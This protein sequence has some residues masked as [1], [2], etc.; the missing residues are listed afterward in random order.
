MEKK[1]SL[2]DNA[3][4]ELINAR[5]VDYA[6]DQFDRISS[7]VMAMSANDDRLDAMCDDAETIRGACIAEIMAFDWQAHISEST[8]LDVLLSRILEAQDAI[9]HLRD[10]FHDVD[11][12][13]EQALNVDI[14][15]LPTFGGAHPDDTTGIYSW[16][17]DRV[18]QAYGSDWAIV[19]RSEQ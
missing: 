13:I 3:L 10:C 12:G 16:D 6:V 8:D 2:N 9:G 19:D 5:P 14:T 1:I 18:L 11:G 4:A 7:E 15:S 17:P